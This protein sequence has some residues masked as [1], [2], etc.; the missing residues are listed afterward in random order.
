[1]NQNSP[2]NR[3]EPQQ[4]QSL[5][6]KCVAADGVETTNFRQKTP[7]NFDVGPH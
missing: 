1:M 3:A 5:I 6:L 4:K 2:Y 7:L